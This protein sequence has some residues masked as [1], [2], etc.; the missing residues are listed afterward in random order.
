[1][2]ASPTR[3]WS[4]SARLGTSSRARRC[5]CCS[6]AIIVTNASSNLSLRTHTVLASLPSSPVSLSLSVLEDGSIIVILSMQKVRTVRTGSGVQPTPGSGRPVPCPDSIPLV[7]RLQFRHM[8]SRRLLVSL[9][10]NRRA[11]AIKPT[12][13]KR[14]NKDTWQAEKTV[15]PGFR[16]AN[17]FP[18]SR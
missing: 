9:A 2:L 18:R 8:V 11:G 4:C 14:T 1:M 10:P 13:L 12:S 17:T 7:I 16:I 15:Y 3:Q 6:V 5:E